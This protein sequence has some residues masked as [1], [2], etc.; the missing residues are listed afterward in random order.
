MSVRRGMD[1]SSMDVAND[2]PPQ[3][4]RRDERAA[5]SVEDNDASD[6]VESLDGADSLIG[7]TIGHYLVGKR[8]GGGAMAAVYRAQDQLLDQSVAIKVVLPGADAV[9]QA[10]FRREARLVS[11]LIHPHIVR[12]LQVG[13]SGGIVYIAMEL[14]DG[15][16]LGELLERHGKLAVPDAARILAAVAAA[17]DYAH[18]KGVVHRDVK[19]SNILLQRAT[20]GAANSIE[21]SLLPYPI[22]PLLSDFGIARALDA[23][24]LTNAGRTIGTPA[25]MAPEQCAG[26][27]EIDGRA[28]IYALGAVFYRCLVG[29]APFSG[30]TTQILHAHVYDPLLIPDDVADALPVP[31]VE[32]LAQALMKEPSQRFD[33]IGV[34]AQELRRVADLP[35]L[36]NGEAADEVVDPTMTMASLPVAKSPTTSTSRV[37]V[38]ASSSGAA[39]AAPRP[40]PLQAVPQK[41]SPLK[42]G[43]RTPVAVPGRNIPHA[44]QVERQAA[45]PRARGS[46]WGMITLVS[47]FA[48]LVVLAVGMLANSMGFGGGDETPQ[49]GVVTPTSPVGSALTPQP[50]AIVPEVSPARPD[51]TEAT[52]TVDGGGDDA[53]PNV[54]PSAEPTDAGPTP[55]PQSPLQFAEP[56]WL[57]A[58]ESFEAGDWEAT[59]DAL[60]LVQ[61]SIEV[62]VPDEDKV[63]LPRLQEMLVTS[64]LGVATEAAAS[65]DWNH[66]VVKVE[67]AIE[68]APSVSM[69][70]D[71][72]VN[73][74]SLATLEDQTDI[75]AQDQRKAL[76]TD[77]AEL[78]GGYASQLIRAGRV[79]D[80]VIHIDYAIR[81]A[82]SQ[83][84]Q[85]RQAA[86][87]RECTDQ[88]AEDDIVALGGT[89]L[90]STGGG[91]DSFNIW[92]MPVRESNS[93]RLLSS[94]LL[95]NASQPSVSPNGSVLAYYSRAEGFDGLYGVR[96]F[97]GVLSGSGEAYGPNPEDSKDSPPSWDSSGTRLA[98]STAFDGQSPHV[99]ITTADTNTSARD[100]G[101]GKDPAWRPDDDLIVFNGPDIGGQNPG[102]HA[103]R[104]SGDGLDRYP[105]SENGNDQR[106]TWTSDGKYVVFMSKDRSGGSSWEVYRMD[107]ATREV[108]LLTD[109]HPLQ[110][111]LP[112]ISP[113]DQWV[114]FMSDRDGQWKLY[115]VS[116]DGGAVHFLSD[117]SGQPISWLEHSIQWMP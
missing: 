37:L 5:F 76:L 113:D 29:R 116:I 35:A 80:A 36:A 30:T 115:Y 108:I 64:Y 11:T 70:A 46:R 49:A 59:I 31:V 32:L 110:D 7:T 9:M 34:M 88:R 77:I 62:G 90:Y 4:G 47:A 73:L 104:A 45:R 38:A 72:V 106:P 22:I 83:E 10:R 94:L 93:D 33:D 21:T 74:K 87:A 41:P 86:V 2:G 6:A 85:E 91:G 15:V 69:F 102:L 57:L 68:L 105:L 54:R 27:A 84:L 92:R 58:L 78:Q 81:I 51:A 52:T 26:S 67:K 63:D 40:N 89:I 66:A 42:P 79:C 1:E 112:A 53:G 75:V 20:R 117:I 17:L 43:V 109:G 13:R 56:T 12:T 98:Y 114:V 19:P 3:R 61:R 96:L 103:M 101:I 99:W 14:V 48:F 65:G 55:T 28:D 50:P 24:E 44:P 60:N 111:G 107:L 25:F 23:P 100:L 39:A 16:S 97:G 71:I 8:L 18:G 95:P 82:D